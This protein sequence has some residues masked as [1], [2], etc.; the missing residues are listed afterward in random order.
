M[1]NAEFRIPLIG[2]RRFGLINFGFLPTEV[3]FYFDGGVAWTADQSPVL[4][5]A[6]NSTQRI[7]VFSTGVSFRINLLG[8]AII[9]IYGAHPFQR[10]QKDWLWGFNLAPGW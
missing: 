5:W 9:E 8:Y 4:K 2:T 6:T 1:I 10:P 3:S 7:P